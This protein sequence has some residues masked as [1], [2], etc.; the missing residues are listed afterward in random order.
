MKIHIDNY[1]LNFKNVFLDKKKGLIN[2]KKYKINY[3][4]FENFLHLSLKKDFYISD[5]YE[6]CL[7]IIIQ[8]I[9]YM[10]FSNNPLIKRSSSINLANILLNNNNNFINNNYIKSKILL[11]KDK[12]KFFNYL[13]LIVNYLIKIDNNLDCNESLINYNLLDILY[14][15]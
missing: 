11:I 3:D 4:Q 1:I 9:E 5:D 8:N 10:N 14:Y 6:E 2:Y 7:D 15:N 13:D 12:D